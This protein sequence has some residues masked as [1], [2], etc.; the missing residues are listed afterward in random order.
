MAERIGRYV[1]YSADDEDVDCGR[2]DN[3]TAEVDCSKFCGADHWWS[4]YRRTVNTQTNKEE[5]IKE[6]F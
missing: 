2:C 1:I 4:G 5:Q 6:Q 3:C